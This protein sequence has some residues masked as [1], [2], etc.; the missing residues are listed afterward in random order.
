MQ[1]KTIGLPK[2][3]WSTTRTQR[4]WLRKDSSCRRMVCIPASMPQ[5]RLTTSPRGTMRKVVT[6]VQR[7]REREEYR[8]V[9][10]S[11]SLHQ[12]SLRNNRLPL[13]AGHRRLRL[14]QRQQ[15]R[16]KLAEARAAVIKQL[17]QLERQR[18]AV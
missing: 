14:Q 15:P 8:A 13:R 18:R 9:E 5:P 6:L 16:A 2:T 1:F 12:Q 3:I 11:R 7:R 17:V 4:F 10:T